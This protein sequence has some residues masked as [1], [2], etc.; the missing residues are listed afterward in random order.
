MKKLI[1]K[2]NLYF[3]IIIIKIIKIKRYINNGILSKE[4]RIPIP[5]IFIKKVI[6]IN[7]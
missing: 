1:K 2:I 7:L 4:S 6:K 5:D 3:L